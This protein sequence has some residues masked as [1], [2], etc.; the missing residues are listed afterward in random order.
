MLAQ[1]QQG[2]AVC[3]MASQ[4]SRRAV[5]VRAEMAFTLHVCR[6]GGEKPRRVSA[7]TQPRR[8]GN[9]WVLC[10]FGR[11]TQEDSQDKFL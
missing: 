4:K 10:V 2:H 5:W 11:L 9:P 3:L 6:K 7:A 1:G 8:A